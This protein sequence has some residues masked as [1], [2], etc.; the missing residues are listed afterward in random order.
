[1]KTEKLLKLVAVG[2]M[3]GATVQAAVIRYGQTGTADA[4][5]YTQT[6]TTA[7]GLD[8]DINFAGGYLYQ[9]STVANGTFGTLVTQ[10]TG[11]SL[12]ETVT[13]KG[14]T[15]SLGAFSGTT[16]TRIG[17]TGG[18]TTFGI[19]G[20]TDP[21]GATG[22]NTHNVISDDSVTLL[23][24]QTMKLHHVRIMTDGNYGVTDALATVIVNGTSYTGA[25]SSSNGGSYIDLGGVEA[26]S[27]TMG[28]GADGGWAMQAL[29][30]ETIP[31]PATLG[32]VAAMGGAILFVRRRFMI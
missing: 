9:N 23:F 1:M 27:L 12:A 10:T 8:L 32:L 7:T 21:D 5:G 14:V 31:E 30:V 13:G 24:N 6:D 29:V 25:V 18:G 4:G 19:R 20:G 15:L 22:V 26:T 28:G 3:V 16:D 11:A 2:V 17:G